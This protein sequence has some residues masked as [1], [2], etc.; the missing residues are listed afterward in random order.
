MNIDRCTVLC[1]YST[2]NCMMMMMVSNPGCHKKKNQNKR[3]Q[4]KQKRKKKIEKMGVDREGAQ[5]QLH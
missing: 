1:T 5:V 2:E 3:G 4:K